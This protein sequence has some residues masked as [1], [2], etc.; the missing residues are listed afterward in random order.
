MLQ[1]NI[2]LKLIKSLSFLYN[3]DGDDTN[4]NLWTKVEK[5]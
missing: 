1:I 2:F 3:I 4:Y 5:L